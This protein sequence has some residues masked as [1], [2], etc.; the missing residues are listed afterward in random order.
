MTPHRDIIVIGGSAGGLEPLR[1]LVADLPADLPAAV[2]V[3]L[4]LSPSH[5]T[6]LPEILS[7]SGPLPAELGVHGHAIAS[8]RIVVAP[9]DNHLMVRD[10]HVVVVRGPKENGHRPAV[11]PLFRSAA[12]AYGRRVIAVLLSGALDCGTA[13]FMVVRARGGLTVVQSP[14]DAQVP[15]MPQSALRHVPVDHVAPSADLGALLARL[16]REP[17]PP[18]QAAPSP[19]PAPGKPPSEATAPL[20]DVVCP[21]CQGVM[22][23][24]RHGDF[25]QMRCHVG[26][27]FSLDGL[28]QMQFDH[29]E[30]AL[31]AGVRALDESA[32]V[33]RRA[34]HSQRVPT[35]EDR[36]RTLENQ[37]EVIRRM[38]LD[39]SWPGP[40][41]G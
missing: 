32:R 19:E 25:V 4:H 24:V 14:E 28:M 31:W 17:L 15:S 22:T 9:P 16:V 2:F 26:H 21:L 40:R 18:E 13:G 5:R 41:P 38:L 37:A 12:A 34:S 29:L 36:A 10:D 8:G 1:R 23:E 35:L 11:D 39:P 20:T 3:A 30:T 7:R 27:A 33:A 6:H